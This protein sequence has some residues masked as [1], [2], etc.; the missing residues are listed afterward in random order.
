MKELPTR[1]LRKKI[2]DGN[3]DKQRKFT[4]RDF[5]LTLGSGLISAVISLYGAS[6]A[7]E[8][9]KYDQDAQAI[10]LSV[11]L[12]NAWTSDMDEETR[13]RFV[14]FVSALNEYK[15][16]PEIRKRLERSMIMEEY[17]YNPQEVVQDEIVMR[18]LDLKPGT[19]SKEVSQ[20]LNRY[21]T[22]IFTS[23][24]AMENIATISCFFGR[25]ETTQRIVD[26]Q[27]RGIIQ[28]RSAELKEF[29]DM[30]NHEMHGVRGSDYEAWKTLYWAF[31]NSHGAPNQCSTPRNL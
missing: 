23:L 31:S 17:L 27:Y 7:S 28:K 3:S 13:W 30:Y 14:R 22:A 19:R 29:I 15:E 8:K 24:N 1:F 25:S 16:K 18:L 26:L 10:Q 6:V 20:E 11:A 21:R 4:V 12:E 9:N 2:Q 5:V